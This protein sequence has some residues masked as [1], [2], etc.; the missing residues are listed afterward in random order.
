MPNS[1]GLQLE[2]IST[3]GR[4]IGGEWGGGIRSS[5]VQ[6]LGTKKWIASRLSKVWSYLSFK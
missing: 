3:D 5:V 1:L 6:A 2:G 4:E